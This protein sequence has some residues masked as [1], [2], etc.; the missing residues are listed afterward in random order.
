MK[1]I[2]TLIIFC[3]ILMQNASSQGVA[4]ADID[5]AGNTFT[6]FELKK[7][8]TAIDINNQIATTITT[9]LFINNTNDTTGFK[10]AFPMRESAAATKIR[11]NYNGWQTASLIAAPQ[12][13]T[14]NADSAVTIYTPALLD[15]FLG[16]TPLYFPVD[17]SIA[18]GDSIMIELTY[19][20]LLSYR[21]NYVSFSYPGRYNLI[22]PTIGSAEFSVSINSYRIIDSILPRGYNVAVSA[23][24]TTQASFSKTLLNTP[25][26]TAFSFEYLLHPDSLG[27]FGFSTFYPDSIEMCD[28]INGFFTFIV[29]PNSESA[30]DIIGKDFVLIIDHSGSMSGTKMAQANEAAEFIV[31][32]LNNGDRFNIVQ[33]DDVAE[34]LSPQFLNYTIQNK[35]TA[36]NYIN[37]ISASGS[38]NISGSFDKAVPMYSASGSSRAKIII[39]FTDG[40]PSAGI[41][42]STQLIA[43][44]KNLITNTA[45]DINL[46]VFGIG[47]DVNTN[48][49][50][51][52]ATQNNGSAAFLTTSNVA[53]AISNFYT[54]IQNP[55]LLNTTITYNPPVVFQTYPNPLPNLYKGQQLIVTGRYTAPGPVTVTMNGTAFGNPVSYQYMLN[56]TDSLI[57]ENS[58]LPKIWTQGKIDYL[59]TQYYLNLSNTQIANDIRKEIAAL[60][61]CRG[62]VSPFTSFSGANNGT[63]GTVGMEE[64]ANNEDEIM[65]LVYP[66]PANNAFKVVIPK[67]YLSTGT[68]SVSICSIDGRFITKIDVALGQD[69]VIDLNTEA[70]MLET[71][72]YILTVEVSGKAFKAR[73]SVL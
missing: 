50:T 15:T 14:F 56:L 42:N 36:L 13:S 22:Q 30:I 46:H 11:W 7:S 41:T 53:T 9:Q 33:F 49:L 37:G 10:Y 73:L 71:G 72:I 2:Y 21:N 70:L 17:L 23:P 60:S 19:V 51:E 61:L 55:V 6:A 27:F 48:L 68:A 26:G 65:L 1:K 45:P 69:G 20:E 5:S 4:I 34:S 25:F 52:L 54:T 31:N 38:T 44:V 18:P 24:G 39:F 28:T 59:M 62:V 32:N 64:I 3:L 67:A 12:D 16:H 40:Q 66:N 35:N 47:S 58:F 63:G 29:E 8:F 57:E 43:H